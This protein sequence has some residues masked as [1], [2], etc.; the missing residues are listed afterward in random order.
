MHFVN[1]IL[2]PPWQDSPTSAHLERAVSSRI[3]GRIFLILFIVWEKFVVVSCL[4]SLPQVFSSSWDSSWICL[5]DTVLQGS[6]RRLTHSILGFKST[7]LVLAINLLKFSISVPITSISSCKIVNIVIIYYHCML[8]PT[9]GPLVSLLLLI[10]FFVL[11]VTFLC[12]FASLIIFF[13][14]LLAGHWIIHCTE[15]I[16]YYPFLKNILSY[17]TRWL[18]YWKFILTLK[19]RGFDLVRVGLFQFWLQSRD[20]SHSLPWT[21]TWGIYT[22]ASPSASSGRVQRPAAASCS[23]VCPGP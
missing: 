22:A 12:F 4:F 19:K 15:S 21:H 13:P 18:N 16:S 1:H 7:S 11:C 10:F 23:G 2:T 20:M 9:S 8:I 17:F 3:P 6:L 14:L 5:T